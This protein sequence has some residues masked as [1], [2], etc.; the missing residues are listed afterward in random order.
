LQLRIISLKKELKH[1]AVNEGCY[2]P[3]ILPTAL[4]LRFKT[5]SSAMISNS[6]DRDDTIDIDSKSLSSHPSNFISSLIFSVT[7][8][9][10][11]D[12]STNAFDEFNSNVQ[13]SLGLEQSLDDLNHDT[14]S[15]EY[16]RKR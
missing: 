2:H 8:F 4:N 6:C 1:Q 13:K 7:N 5:I 12:Q 10:N 16:H 3:P 14:D 9:L 15:S 11:I